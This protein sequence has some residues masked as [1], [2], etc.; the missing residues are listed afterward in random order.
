MTKKE[1][2]KDLSIATKQTTIPEPILDPDKAK[3][4]GRNN[5]IPYE[6]KMYCA[7]LLGYKTPKK[8]LALDVAKRWGIL[9][10]APY[11]FFNSI[12]SGKMI[13]TKEI[14]ETYLEA[15]RRWN[16]EIEMEPLSSARERMRCFQDIHEK[17]MIPRPTKNLEGAVFNEKGEKIFEG[18][19]LVK[20]FNAEA[21]LKA[22]DGARKEAGQE[23]AQRSDQH[24]HF[25][26]DSDKIR[27]YKKEIEDAPE[28]ERERVKRD[29]EKELGI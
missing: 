7:A 24:I 28:E 15:K 29:L 27:E 10:K 11:T 5:P 19:F 14:Q 25:H 2:K 1:N 26:G 13:T 17:A 18:K 4:L 9:F 23:P 16:K 12:T 20:E 3:L 6:V 8:E 22:L 21:A